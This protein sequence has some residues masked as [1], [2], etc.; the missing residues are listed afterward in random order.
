M[1]N[2]IYAYI[3]IF[4]V[5]I[6]LFVYAQ[7]DTIKYLE[8]FNIP[9]YNK[10]RN[11]ADAYLSKMCR[12]DIYYPSNI[13]GFP[14]LIWFHGGGLSA[15]DKTIPE[16]LKN[17]GI[18]IVSVGY[19][20]SPQVKTPAFIEDA[21]AATA[22]V[23]YNIKRIGGDT[24]KIFISGH[25]AGGYLAMM[26]G[27]DKKWLGKY[28]LNSDNLAGIIPLSG[29]T[30]THFVVRKERGIPDKQ[31]VIDEFAPIYYVREKTPPL[32]LITGDKDL[33]LLGRYEENAYMWRMMRVAGNKQ[34]YLHQLSGFDHGEMVRPAFPLLF[35]YMRMLIK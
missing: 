5:S 16:E 30:I 21:A 2:K 7:K 25:S 28:N 8:D 14:T 18:A 19:R 17:N 13:S 35:K 29:H 22:W 3:L 33:E 10:E 20:L 23:M 31:P 12:L 24:S 9:Y 26:I 1:I 4:I 6:P 34:V 15:G 11:D 32:V 27:L